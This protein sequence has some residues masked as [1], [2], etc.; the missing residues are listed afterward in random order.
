MLGVS[1][2]GIVAGTAVMLAGAVVYS[3]GELVGGPVH[4]SVA[5]ESAPDHL[6]GR[7]LSLVQLSWGIAGAVTPA[8]YL[9]LLDR[10][11]TPLW[12]V[13]LGITAVGCVL[14]SIVGRIVPRAGQPITNEAEPAPA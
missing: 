5:A 6:R 13:M 10:G 12:L 11:A 4:A 7:Y 14:S 2:I 9:W 1:R 3:M 8:A